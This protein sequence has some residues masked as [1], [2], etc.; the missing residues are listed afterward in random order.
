[1]IFGISG[2]KRTVCNREVS[3]LQRCP[4]GEVRLYRATDAHKHIIECCV[5][6]F[7]TR[8]YSQTFHAIIYSDR[9]RIKKC[10]VCSEL[11]AHKPIAVLIFL[12]WL[13]S[14][15][16][17]ILQFLQTALHSFFNRGR[18]VSNTRQHIRLLSLHVKTVKSV[19]RL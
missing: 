13:F 12:L 2:I 5:Y 10:D 18:K 15:I 16:I 11:F 19:D 7:S 14:L 1:M 3:V 4:Y 17:I 9:Q 6:V 8:D